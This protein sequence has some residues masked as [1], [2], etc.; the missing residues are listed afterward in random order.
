MKI[1]EIPLFLGALVFVLLLF[2]VFFKLGPNELFITFEVFIFICATVFLSALL[3]KIFYHMLSKKSA[4]R[5]AGRHL[6]FILAIILQSVVILKFVPVP[7]EA[8]FDMR[9]VVLLVTVSSTI[10]CYLALLGSSLYRR[11]RKPG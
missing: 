8:K 4:A 1:K 10:V 9:G 3:V 5:P 6:T 11:N 7:Q 2:F